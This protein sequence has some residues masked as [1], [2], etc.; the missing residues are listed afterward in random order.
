VSPLLLLHLGWRSC[1]DGG[2]R[3][4]KERLGYCQP[5]KQERIHVHAASVGE[6]ITVL[7]LIEK[8]QSIDPTLKFLVSTNTPTGLAILKDRL[9]V[10]ASQ[11]YLPID[12][13]GATARFFCKKKITR[14]WIVET[15]IWPW[16]FARAKQNGI[17][18]TVV[19]ARLSHKS[20]GVLA[21]FFNQTYTNTLADVS[22]LARSSEDAA[23]YAQ[24]GAHPEKLSTVGNLKYAALANTQTPHSLLARPY[25]LAAS[26]H[27][28]EELQLAQAWLHSTTDR[29]LVIAPRHAERGAR[30]I[31]SLNALQQEI[32]PDLPAVAQRSIGEQPGDKCK[33]YLADTLGEMHH[34][35]THAG[36]AFVGGSLIKRGGHNVLEP[37]RAATAIVVGPHTYNFAEEVTMLQNAQAIAL[38]DNADNVIRLLARA[39]SDT[40][41]AQN[42]GE[43]AK[44][45]INAQSDVLDHYIESLLGSVS[46]NLHD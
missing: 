6:V 14:L 46:N 10:N 37:G 16:L 22:I 38:A 15:E 30:L 32:C 31:K 26:T 27:E 41:W 18:I 35:Y 29:L 45:A 33:L 20:N 34:W 17:P 5:D 42:M 44:N 13:S 19:N 23:R 40:Q 1:R 7:P 8:L 25:V 24:R 28:D 2:L 11:T 3:Y 21:N 39:T 12:F 9:Q 36:A 43:R 4:I